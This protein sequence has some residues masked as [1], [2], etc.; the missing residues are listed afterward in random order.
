MAHESLPLGTHVVTISGDKL[1]GGPQAG[2]LLGDEGIIAQIRKNPLTRAFRVDKVTLAGLEATL[3]HYLDAEEALREI[4][5]LRMLAL[6]SSTLEARS[7]SLAEAFRAV[8]VEVEVTEGKGVVGG[9]TF[10]GV[11]LPGWKL[12]VR[13]GGFSA[14]ALARRL[15][16]GDPPVVGRIEDDDLIL[17]LRTVEAN[18]EE[19]LL[20]S[21]RA[22][23]A[24]GTETGEA[25]GG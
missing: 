9:G 22:V 7:R 24:S 1:L 3:S 17:D 19:S 11:G 20:Q 4:P 16:E 8:G 15:R 5:A 18:Q 14:Q 13:V 10:P 6:S 21:L 2:I 23:K 25:E 12:R